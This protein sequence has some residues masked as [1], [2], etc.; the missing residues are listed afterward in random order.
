MVQDQVLIRCQVLCN[1]QEMI[2]GHLLGEPLLVL[3]IEQK[4]S[5]SLKHQLLIDTELI[6]SLRHLILI[7]LPL[8][9]NSIMFLTNIELY[10]LVPT[11]TT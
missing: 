5:Q 2:L 10:F 9:Q 6:N 3:Q 1:H 8:I 7:H 11:G 4:L